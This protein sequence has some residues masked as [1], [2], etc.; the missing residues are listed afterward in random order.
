M[1]QMQLMFRNMLQAT[2][3]QK[4]TIMG[5]HWRKKNM[6][7]GKLGV[8]FA[9]FLKSN[10]LSNLNPLVSNDKIYSLSFSYG[11]PTKYH[12]QRGHASKVQDLKHKVYLQP[13]SQEHVHNSSFQMFLC[14]RI[15]HQI[16]EYDVIHPCRSKVV[17]IWCSISLC[18]ISISALI[19]S[20]SSMNMREGVVFYAL[21][22]KA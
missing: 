21:E 4:P 13:Q 14:H 5:N 10:E 19:T 12:D 11:N 17:T 6:H 18:K 8:H 9:T 7:N 3:H 15:G 20:I 16:S 22:K 1:I 2:S